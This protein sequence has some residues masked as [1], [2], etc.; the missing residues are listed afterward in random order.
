MIKIYLWAIERLKI[1]DVFPDS[2]KIGRSV[3]ETAEYHASLWISLARVFVKN[4]FHR[5]IQET[6]GEGFM[7]KAIEAAPDL[8]QEKDTTLAVPS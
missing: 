2:T 3:E 7:K 1:S 8:F 4:G 5:G 6:C